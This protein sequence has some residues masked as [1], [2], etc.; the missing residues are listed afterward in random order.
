[1]NWKESANKRRTIR[2][3]HGDPEIPA[4]KTKKKYGLCKK[5]KGPHV[6]SNEPLYLRQGKLKVL[7]C[8]NCGKHLEITFLGPKIIGFNWDKTWQINKSKTIREE[9]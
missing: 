9:D 6:I 3:T 2:Q 8:K 4:Y 7:V 1:M 5:G